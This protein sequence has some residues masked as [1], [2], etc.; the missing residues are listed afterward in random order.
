[1]M[2]RHKHYDAIIAYANGAEIEIQ[3]NDGNWKFV[4]NP[5]WVEE[6]EYRIKP[7]EKKLT[8]C[9]LWARNDGSITSC[10]YSEN[11]ASKLL[12]NEYPIKLLWSETMLDLEDEE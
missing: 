6:M 1:M 7:A 5:S 4:K 3:D 9:Y 12:N 10:L 11:E 8:P 2:N